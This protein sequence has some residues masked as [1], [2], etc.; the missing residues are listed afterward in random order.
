ML[1]QQLSSA[2]LSLSLYRPCERT[3]VWMLHW[4]FSGALWESLSLP[5]LSLYRPSPIH[6]T[7]PT[8]KVTL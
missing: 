2:T 6:S 3:P 1:Q 8:G 7:H 4:G 5:A